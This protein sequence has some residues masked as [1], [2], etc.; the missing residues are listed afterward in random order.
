MPVTSTLG[1]L[2]LSV[3]VVALVAALVKHRGGW[4]T[5]EALIPL[6]IVLVTIHWIVPMPDAM[7]IALAILSLM[8]S[9]SVFWQFMRRSRSAG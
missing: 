8:I 7:Q 1:T 2:A 5:T 3:A 6:A 9:G 4:R